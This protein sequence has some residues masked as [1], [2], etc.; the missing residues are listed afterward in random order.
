MLIPS[1]PHMWGFEFD[2]NSPR[3]PEEGEPERATLDKFVECEG[4]H[5]SLEDCKRLFL[6]AESCSGPNTS[7]ADT[8]LGEQS[9]LVDIVKQE[10]FQQKLKNL[11]DLFHITSGAV[12]E[13][14]NWGL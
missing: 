2:R 1:Q 8:L 14:S 13:T 6:E 9:N 11:L 5:K 12:G 7:W 3:W 10:L 4:H